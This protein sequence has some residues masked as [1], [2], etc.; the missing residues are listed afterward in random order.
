[1]PSH[2]LR[3]GMLGP[4]IRMGIPETAERS[5]GAYSGSVMSATV[6]PKAETTSSAS[7]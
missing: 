3:R 4:L 1:M 6:A 7:A 5:G 2:F